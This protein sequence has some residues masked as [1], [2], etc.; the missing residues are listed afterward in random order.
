M[1]FKTLGKPEKPVA[2]LIHAMFFSEK[3][4]DSICQTLQYSHY[5]VLPTLDAHTLNE[6]STFLSVQDEAKKIADYLLKNDIQ[7]IDILLGTSLGGIIAFELFNLQKISVSHIF[8]D[9]T[10]FIRFSDFRI[11]LMATGFKWIAHKSAKSP[12]RKNLLD[13]LYPTHA[14]EM[15]KICGGMSDESISNIAFAC[16]TYE[17]PEKIDLK[18][19][20]DLTFLYGTKERAR[21]CISTVE[22]YA[23]CN[24]IIKDGYNHCEFLAKE[25]QAYVRMLLNDF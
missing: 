20:Q 24:L 7:H 3:M 9:G 1:K 5:I 12:S 15:K 8:L 17:L 22:K 11:K 19:Q 10:P 4:F 25:P 16:Y 2:V 13:K 14:A 18:E 21:I 6:N 23:N